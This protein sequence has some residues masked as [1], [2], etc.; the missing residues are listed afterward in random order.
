MN[1][2]DEIAAKT[3]ERIAQEKRNVSPET[4]R[5]EAEA[6]L[7][8]ETE[9]AQ[10]REAETALRRET[11]AAQRREAE[12]ILQWELAG[13]QKEV[14]SE[15]GKA[16]GVRLPFEA[17]L[18][19]EG[20]SFICEVKK[21]SPSKGIIAE[22]FPYLNIAKEYEA[23][24]AAAISCLTEPY[25]FLGK[26]AYL[27]EIAAQVNIPVLRKDFTVDEYMIYQAK[28]LGASAVLLIC[29][30]LDDGQ[31]KAYGQL[32]AELGMSALVEAHTEEEIARALAADARILGINN[33]NLKNFQVDITQSRRLRELVP[34]D[35][36]FV[37]ESGIKTPQDVA[38]LRQN[39][40]DAVLIGETLMRAPDKKVMLDMLRGNVV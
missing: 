5:R 3:R 2:L 36:L 22:E 17:A 10:C 9:A 33:R 4:M 37:S 14:S 16:C 32:A 11:E 19:A 38:A 7:R 29:A 20:I 6:A 39:G 24:G 15:T 13:A 27:Q 26:D 31:L 12:S 40:T 21:A 23:A 35:V 18:A 25:W 28:A 8:H 1:I 30:I 34:D